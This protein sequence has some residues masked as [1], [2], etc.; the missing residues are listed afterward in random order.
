LKHKEKW[1]E[2]N[3]Y[4]GPK[5]PHEKLIQFIFRT[6]TTD[7]HLVRILDLGC[8][9]GA[10]TF[11]LAKE[12]FDVCATDISSIAVDNTLRRLG[13]HKAEVR[14]GTVSDIDFVDKTFDCVVSIGVLECAGSAVFLEAIREIVRVLKPGGYAFLMFASESDFRITG[15]NELKLHG[16][17]DEEVA[18]TSY[19]VGG[20]LD[21]FWMDRYITTHA[22][23]S[24]QENN[25]LITFKK[26]IK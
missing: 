3:T 15:S 24:S 23:K 25:H 10:N 2:W 11:F 20:S 14:T 6:F 7:R 18:S 17:T 13:G 22:N 19:L 8:G 26:S 16:F 21:F 1:D 9:S 4:F 5:Y 12:K